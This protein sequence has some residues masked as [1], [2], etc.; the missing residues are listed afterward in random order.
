MAH[1]PEYH[2]FTLDNGLQCV[3]RQASAVGY[4]GVVINAGSCDDG[5]DFGLAHFVEHTIFK[6]THKRRSR[7]IASRMESVGGDLNAYTSKDETTVYTAYPAGFSARALELLADL[8]A[9]ST[10]PAAELD[11]ERD[12]V[13][14]EINLYLD[15]PAESIFDEFEDRI[16]AD[17]PAGHNILG[18]PESVAKINTE[19]CL[20]FRQRYYTGRN[21]A[22]YC[23]DDCSPRQAF[24][25]INRYFGSLPCGERNHHNTE[26]AAKASLFDDIITQEGHQAHTILGTR[27]S[28]RNDPERFALFLLNN[29]LGGP[30]MNSLLN[31]ELRDKRGYVYTVDSSVNLM[32]DCGIFQI[33][34]GCD[35][36]HTESC[37]KL[38]RRILSSLAETTMKPSIFDRIRRQYLGQITVSSDNRESTAMGL[39]KSLLRFGEIHDASFTAERIMALT[40]EQVR[41]TAERILNSGL[42]RLTIDPVSS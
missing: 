29:H 33:Y 28:H 40:A 21:M 13:V 20:G 25:N 17:S 26:G 2:I 3:F 39:G 30:S 10:F 24:S 38:A 6:G 23:V 19:K 16:F 34:F 22:L 42:S 7:H 27:I 31:R 4:C 9:D 1:H 35:R 18:T 36:R 11:K 41:A 14:D 37:I 12:V 5:S 32:D 8:V 15:N